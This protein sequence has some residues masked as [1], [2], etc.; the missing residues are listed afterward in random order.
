MGASRKWIHGAAVL[1]GLGA[2]AWAEPA[3]AFKMARCSAGYSTWSAPSG[4]IAVTTSDGPIRSVLQGVNEYFTHSI[5]S[6][7]SAWATHSTSLTPSADNDCDH[8]LKQSE[9]RNGLPGF[10]QVRIGGIYNYARSADS[11]DYVHPRN[12]RE[13]DLHPW[14]QGA[15]EVLVNQVASWLWS[16]APFQWVTRVEPNAPTLT[17]FV[18]VTGGYYKLGYYENNVFQHMPYNFYQYRAGTRRVAGHDPVPASNDR[19]IVCS[20]VAPYA[21]AK[22]EGE[23]YIDPFLY[24][25]YPV[26]VAGNNLWHT[27]NDEC[28]DGVGFWDT[29]LAPIGTGCT[30]STL[31]NH[32]A[33]QV[34]NCFFKGQNCDDDSSG[35]WNQFV[36]SANTD[37][38]GLGAASI[39]PDF[40][41]GWG[42]NGYPL[43]GN[44]VSPWAAYQIYA[45]NFSGPDVYECYWG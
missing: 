17:G 11:D 16:S 39:S 19:G 25:K 41:I 2:L 35:A 15:N 1:G 31:C 30:T 20:Q 12:W 10:S 5:V 36:Q 22:S 14:V 44:R 32:A 34:L 29:V 3:Q 27:V 42:S 40:L 18:D 38:N 26:A 23:Y 4:A 37:P 8:P 45:L 43:T 28:K 6:H 9:L 24:A 7:G 21:L 33:W 13:V